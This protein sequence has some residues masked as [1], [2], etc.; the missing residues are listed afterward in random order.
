MTRKKKVCIELQEEEAALA[1][2]SDLL[3]NVISPMGSHH[4]I[5]MQAC[6]VDV[7]GCNVPGV[8]IAV[9]GRVVGY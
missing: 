6:K 2:G 4:R 1:G 5:Q 3:L 8:V 9:T 7:G